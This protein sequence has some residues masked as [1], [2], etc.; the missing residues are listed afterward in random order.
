M[1]ES[2]D[3]R[4]VVAD[5]EAESLSHADGKHPGQGCEMCRADFLNLWLQLVGAQ[6][7]ILYYQQREAE[8]EL[9]ELSNE[10][11]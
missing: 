11:H 6:R 8:A 1:S 3:G 5:S 10:T 9:N 7:Q 2:G 4:T